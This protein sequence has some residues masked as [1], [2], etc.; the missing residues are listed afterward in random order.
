MKIKKQ[1]LTSEP[2]NPPT[3]SLADPTV[4]LYEPAVRFESSLVTAPEDDAVKPGILTVACDA[5]YSAS[6]FCCFTSPLVCFIVSANVNWLVVW[7][8]KIFYV[9]TWSV[10]LPVILPRTFWA[11]PVTESTTD[12]RVDV[13]LLVDMLN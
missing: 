6:A 8:R 3:V 5:S 9:H 12:W 1:V 10:V 7:C 2:T 11:A 13:L 4:W